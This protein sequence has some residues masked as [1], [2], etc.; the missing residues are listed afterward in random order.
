[1]SCGKA[2]QRQGSFALFSLI[3]ALIQVYPLLLLIL[4][5]MDELRSIKFTFLVANILQNVHRLFTH[6][7][8]VA[9]IMIVS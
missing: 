1:M 7:E 5:E 8:I 3:L 2:D 4:V 9:H 6:G